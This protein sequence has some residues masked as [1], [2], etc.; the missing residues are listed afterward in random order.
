MGKNSWDDSKTTTTPVQAF[1]IFLAVLTLVLP[2]ANAVGQRSP[3]E[4][5]ER[6]CAQGRIALEYLIRA[7]KA[8]PERFNT[9]PHDHTH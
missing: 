5:Y 2:A 1:S 3:A 8:D 7:G 9:R 6:Y 4:Y